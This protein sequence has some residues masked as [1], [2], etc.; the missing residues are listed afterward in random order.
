M[1]RPASKIEIGNYAFNYCINVNISRSFDTFTD[2]A[3]IT[4]P[5]TFRDV[6]KN[7]VNNNG[8]FKKGDP[9]KIKLG[10]YPYLTTVFEG[11][12]NKIVP[13]SPLVIE[14]ED[15][16]WKLKQLNIPNFTQKDCTL[17]QLV[18]HLVGTSGIK[19]NA[20][21]ANIGTFRISNKDYVNVVDCLNELKNNFGL[22]SW[23]RNGELNVGYPSTQQFYQ[24][25]NVRFEFQKDIIQSNLE[26]QITTQTDVILQGISNKLDN[27]KITRY[28]FYSADGSITVSDNPGQG[29]QR[30]FNYIDLSLADLDERLK[31]Q[32]PNMIY[33]GYKG[34][35]TTFGHPVV[36]PLDKVTLIDNKFKEREGKYLVKK[37]DTSFGMDGYRQNIELD[38]RL[39]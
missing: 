31:N 28:C 23:F 27:T 19:F 18:T 38:T 16:S 10:Y 34:S 20:V 25:Y 39:I 26:Y 32:L 2:T 36:F 24:T 35:F 7:M 8:I 11:Y 29:E 14:C 9:V 37:V 22:Y 33:N 4:I 12:V 6:N 30:T 3:K 13:N 21:D 15:A 1:L 17:K 5:S